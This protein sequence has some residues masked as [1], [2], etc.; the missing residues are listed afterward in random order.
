VTIKTTP[1]EAESSVDDKRKPD[2]HVAEAGGD[3]DPT[4]Q[5]A[6]NKIDQ[7]IQQLDPVVRDELSGKPEALAEWDAIMKD[8]A[9]GV[10]EDAREAE[11]AKLQQEINEYTDRIAAQVDWLASLDPI[12]LQTNLEV[13]ETMARNFAAWNE[14]D[15]IMHLRCRE[16]PDHLARWEEEIMKPIRRYEAI[17][18][19]G[20]EAENARPEN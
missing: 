18:A 1:N 7:I 9:Q 12:D 5:E 4:L 8:Y 20:R 16:Y 6:L 11:E 3:S 14:L 15:A 10:A 19:A 13:E 17:F 2:G